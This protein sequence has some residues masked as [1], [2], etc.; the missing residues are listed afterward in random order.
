MLSQ[1]LLK[2]IYVMLVNGRT[3]AINN[4]YSSVGKCVATYNSYL[5]E[6]E[7]LLFKEV[8][9]SNSKVP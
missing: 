3:E 1:E 4:G 7:P 6:I 2:H 8:N 5:S 9:A